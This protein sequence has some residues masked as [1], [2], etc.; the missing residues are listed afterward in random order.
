MRVCLGAPKAK[1]LGGGCKPSAE[2]KKK[3]KKAKPGT[4]VWELGEMKG[5]GPSQRKKFPSR[6]AGGKKKQE[7]QII[8]S[9]RVS[10]EGGTAINSRDE[11]REK[12]LTGAPGFKRKKRKKRRGRG[13]KNLR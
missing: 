3:R 6:E 13:G 2:K 8:E 11:E 7:R 12:V 10:E 5:E 4:G 1:T 9:F